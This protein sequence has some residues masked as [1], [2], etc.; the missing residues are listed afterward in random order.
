MNERF[1]AFVTKV[2]S[3]IAESGDETRLLQ[4]VT[5][6]MRSLV[7]VDD[8]LPPEMAVP[9]PRYYR[10]YLLHCDRQ[11][12]FS[13][14]SFVW[15]PGQ[16]TPI[17]D[18]TVWGVIGMLR[19][20]EL[21]QAF[22]CSPDGMAPQGFPARLEPGDVAAV[23]PRIGDIHRVSNAYDDR[24]S[25]SIHVYGAD[26]GQQR[27]HVFDPETGLAQEFISGYSQPAKEAP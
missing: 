17:H 4:Q 20:T 21:A 1:Q 10:Q 23:S 9:H 6:A 18:H 8:W 11:Q 7:A 14:V 2:A 16:A 24:V 19:G 27:R 15:G 13:V 26:I 5:C 22:T 3:A 12:R 25:I